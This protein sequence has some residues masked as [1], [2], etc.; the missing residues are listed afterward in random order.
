LSIAAYVQQGIPVRAVAREAGHLDGENHPDLAERDAR[1]DLLEALPRCCGGAAQPKIT[2]Y[3]FDV[4]FPPA[5][6]TSAL[7]QCVL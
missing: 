5:E 4:R 3:D 2:V 6:I 7:A 1:N